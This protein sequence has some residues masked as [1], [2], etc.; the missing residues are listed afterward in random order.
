MRVAI[1]ASGDGSN[2]QALTED[3]EIKSAVQ[4][5]VC[6]KPGAF[7]VERAKRADITFFTFAAK[8]FTDKA[9]YERQILAEL[10]KYNVNFI[11]LAGYMRLIGTTLLTQ[12]QGKIINLH[13][14]LLPKFPG[15][16]AIGQALR[17]GES[18]TGVTAH[19]V[20]EGMDTGTII[21]QAEVAILP[22]EGVSEL[23]AN[24]HQ[25]E[26]Q[27][28]PR[29]VKRLILKQGEDLER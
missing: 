19:F 4:L 21:D 22:G 1:F 11:V 9:A 8:D 13:P 15:K 23:T 24:I 20:D 2:F 16:D 12:F 29:V 3:P 5:L 18:K 26:H 28:Y 17:A 10:K 27:F 7:V 6:D 25:V 14:S